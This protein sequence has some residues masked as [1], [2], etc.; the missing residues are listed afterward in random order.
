MQLGDAKLRW[1]ATFRTPVGFAEAL[2][3]VVAIETPDADNRDR[4][5]EGQ[6]E[7]ARLEAEVSPS[8]ADPAVEPVH[9]QERRRAQ[10]DEEP[11]RPPRSAIELKQLARL[12]DAVHGAEPHREPREARDRQSDRCETRGGQGD[13][14]PE[15]EVRDDR[16]LEDRE[17]AVDAGEGDRF[18]AVGR[19]VPDPFQCPVLRSIRQS[20]VVT[21][22]EQKMPARG[23]P[24][25]LCSA[26]C[27][28]GQP[29]PN[30]CKNT[31]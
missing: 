5:V 7:V 31:M 16:E 3:V 13:D 29:A 17:A 18:G 12:L 20:T 10:H 11:E 23:G 25:G 14:E 27:D 2:T 30:S 19:N 28:Y 8:D 6:A 21:I 26:R 22:S 24:R 9:R 1:R 4:V 15:G